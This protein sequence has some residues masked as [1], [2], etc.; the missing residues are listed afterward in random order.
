MSAEEASM[1]PSVS[2]NSDRYVAGEYET[3]KSRAYVTTVKSGVRA[4]PDDDWISDL[5]VSPEIARLTLMVCTVLTGI[6]LIAILAKM[7]PIT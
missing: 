2:G 1:T 6:L 3:W 4:C 5:E 7:W